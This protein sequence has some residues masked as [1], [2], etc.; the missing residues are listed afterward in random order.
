[1]PPSLWSRVLQNGVAQELFQSH[2][3]AW[4]ALI[5]LCLF[6]AAIG[7]PVLAPFNAFDPGSANVADARLPPGSTGMFGNFYLLGTDPQG[8]DLLSAM[9]YGLRTSLAVGFGSVALA[10][11]IG[12]SFGLL[13][14]Y[15]GGII[16]AV[17]MRIADIQ[18][19]L[20]PILIA[21]LVDGVTLT[22]LDRSLHDLLAIP[23]LIFAI[24]TS[25]WVQFARTVRAQVQV[26]KNKD[27]ILA[28]QI[29]GVRTARILT[30][31]ILPNVMAPVL[32][33]ATV[34]LAVAILVES[35]LS[36]LGVG[37]PSTQPSLG[38]LI[39]IGNEF[40]FSGDWWMSILPGGLL[41]VV[42][43]SINLLGDWLRDRLNPTMRTV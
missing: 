15:F 25:L 21:L 33:I 7:A 24:S 5:V 13:S 32:V 42:A 38:T 1:M 14:G 8:R 26:E 41:V 12:V 35:T 36:F 40:L 11:L 28:A 19:S 27:Y 3:A 43:L 18:L 31:H 17:V 4:S 9:M 34:N 30:G 6:I 22:V 16:D 39:R 10:A 20:P 29:T 23:T 37:V 2:V